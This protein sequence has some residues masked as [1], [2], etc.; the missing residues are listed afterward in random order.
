MIN[1]IFFLKEKNLQLLFFNKLF[2]QFKEIE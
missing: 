2:T 1:I